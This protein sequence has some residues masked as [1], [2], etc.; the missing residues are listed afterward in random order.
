MPFKL[1]TIVKKI[2]FIPNPTNRKIVNEFHQYM[3]ERDSSVNH[4]INNLKV[5]FSF[6]NYLGPNTS[7]HDI[8]KKEQ[9]L[10]FLDLKKK[11]LEDDKEK[12]WITTWNYYLHR[13][14]LF[15]RWLYNRN[16]NQ[17][18]EMHDEDLETPEFVRIKTKKT[19]RVSPYSESE[20]WERQDILLITKYEQH[21]RN[22]A[23]LTLLWDL[24]ARPH[25]VTLLKI[26][27]I[28]IR[29]RYGE[30]EIPHEAKTGSG[31]VLL[32]CS[33]PYVRDWLNEH[34]FRNE[35][36]A[37]LICN[38]ITGAPIGPEAIW[39]LMKQLRDRIIRLLDNAGIIDKE[40]REK[41]KHL[42]N[43]KKW[44]P[45]C[46]RHSAITADSDFL[47]EYALKKKVRWSM[48]SKQGARYIKRRMGN[49]LKQKILIHN[50]IISPEELERKPSV[51][52]CPRCSLVNAVENKYCSGCSYPLVS[53]AYDE[54]KEKEEIRIKTMENTIEDLRKEI[55]ITREGQRE[56]FDLLK[57]PKNLL[58][59]LA[60]E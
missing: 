7:F 19:N 40:E 5:I 13:I 31:P 11:T 45:Y 47:P 37:R 38:L 29:E 16:K 58:E 42:I 43:T 27:H 52:N 35:S 36:E 22:K 56:L 6:A 32:T 8:N 24:D 33:F 10:Q 2:E 14:K 4:Q 26:K 28:S 48:N 25:E 55:S 53:S 57:S 51:L 1:N 34:P 20:L 46:I 18:D 60:N 54:I 59:I 9:I 50:G 12:R 15:Y 41:L 3:S 30:G 21:K 17:S 23:I 44:N 39:T 49:D